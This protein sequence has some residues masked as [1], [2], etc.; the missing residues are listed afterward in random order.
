ML[1]KRKVNKPSFTTSTVLLCPIYFIQMP[2]QSSFKE[3][4]MPA[5]PYLTLMV[6]FILHL[7]YLERRSDQSNSVAVSFLA[8]SSCPLFFDLA[9]SQLAL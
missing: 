6:Y 7:F 2:F 1:T 9:F 3:T 5:V 4:D 8:L